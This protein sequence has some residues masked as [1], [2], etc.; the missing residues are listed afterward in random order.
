LDSAQ[1]TDGLLASVAEAAYQGEKLDE[2]WCSRSGPLCQ[3]SC[4]FIYSPSNVAGD[5][6]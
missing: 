2:P 3:D 1:D 6:K 4:R 5:G